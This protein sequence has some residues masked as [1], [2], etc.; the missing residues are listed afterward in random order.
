MAFDKARTALFVANTAQDTIV[1]IPLSG[2]AL[3]PGQPQVFVHRVGGGPDGLHVD[4]QDRLWVA[5]NQSNEILVLDTT[6][7]RVLGKLGDFGGIDR[8]GRPVGLLWPNS[9]AFRGDDVLVTNLALDV[10]TMMTRLADELGLT[11]LLPLNLR[12]VDG[13]WAGEVRL[14]TVSRISKR[15]ATASLLRGAPD[16]TAGS[17]RPTTAA[18]P[19]APVRPTAP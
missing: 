1:R 13:P 4:E 12:T 9:F 6:Q 2:P 18:L 11:A 14:H 17:A 10:G 7:G 3:E 19:S 5:C 16:D 8:E 15:A